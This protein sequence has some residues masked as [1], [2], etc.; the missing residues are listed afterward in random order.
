MFPKDLDLDRIVASALLH[1]ESYE[2]LRR[3]CD[4]V[5][6]RV[7]GSPAGTAAE[8]WAAEAFRRFGLESRF[9]DFEIEAWERGDLEA[10]ALGPTPWRLCALSHG[11]S[12]RKASLV[13]EVVDAGHG[14]RGDL[15]RLADRVPGRW[16]LCDEGVADGHRP[17]HRSEKLALAAEFGAAGLL[18]YSSAPGNLPRTG[19]CA[20]REAPIPGIGIS[21]EDGCRLKRL[22]AS[23]T[24]VSVKVEM[25]NRIQRATVRNVIAEIPG[26]E[27]PEE[28]VLAGAHLDSWD[29]AQGATDNGLGCAIVLDLAR[30][31][32][33]NLPT[34]RRTLRF[35]LWAAEEVGLLGSKHH[36]RLWADDLRNIV[37]VL[38]FDM[39]GSPHGYWIPGE[40]EMPTLFSDLARALDGLGMDPCSFDGKPGL[41]SDHQ[42]FMLEGVP[43]IGLLGR[44]EGQGGH[45][46]HAVGDTFEKVSKP[47][48]C[49]AVAVGASTMAAL[50]LSDE[51]PLPHR[52][53]EEVIRMLSEAGLVEALAVEGWHP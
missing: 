9:E 22:L 38:N 15:E 25:S 39:T 10:V 20:E 26:R 14:E 42:P 7:A 47:G 6:G 27:R 18:L 17:L 37:A 11:N 12:P 44:L 19:M 21:Q 2:L 29:P 40:P 48:L 31:L 13:T 3:L 51:R 33:S 30:V 28:V 32:A 1:N 45:Y 50:A 24:A 49:R 53:R 43:V 52:S 34:T 8:E 23:G 16:V 5:G 36:A 4:D 35:A 46:Y 41:H